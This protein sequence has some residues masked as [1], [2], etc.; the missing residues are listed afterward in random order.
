MRDSLPQ[1]ALGAGF[2]T[3]ALALGVNA[4]T[5]PA[6]RTFITKAAKDSMAEIELGRIAQQKAASEEV[7]RFAERMVADHGKASE[8][9]QKIA[10]GRGVTLPTEV[11]K[12]QKAHADKLQ[13]LSGAE[14]DRAYMKHMVDDHRKAIAEFEKASKGAKDPEVKGFAESKLPALKEHLQMAQAADSAVKGGKAAKTAA[15][16]TPARGSTNGA[17]ANS[18]PGSQGGRMPAAQEPGGKSA[19]TLP[20]GPDEKAPK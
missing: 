2:L 15:L 6:D 20:S 19:T 9:L 10:G 11:D 7:K 12:G 16:G 5:A 17:A 1:A 13:R 14:F 4:E 18:A 8:E 3:L